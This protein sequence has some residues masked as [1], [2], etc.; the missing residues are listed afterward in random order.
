MPLQRVPLNN[1]RGGLNTRDSPFELQPNESPDLLNVTITD[2]VG[3]LTVRAGKARFDTANMPAH[4][5]DHLQQVV[6]GAST[7]WLMCSINGSVYS[8]DVG[9]ALTLRHAGTAGTVW[10]FVQCIDASGVDQVWMQNGVDTPQKWDGAAASTSDWLATTGSLANS[11]VLRVWRN[12]LTV[13]G[14][15]SDPATSHILYLSPFGDPEATTAAYDFI[16]FRGPDDEEAAITEL[17]VLADRL[18]VFNNRS[19]W[20][21]A[22]PSTLANRRLGQ[23]GCSSRFQSDVCENKLYWFN[24]QGVWST[25]GVAIEYE[26]GSV[27]SYFPANLTMAHIDKVRLVATRDAYPRVMLALPVA[28]SSTNNVLMELVPHINFRR[29]GGR[30]YLL[31]PAFMLHTLACQS[32]GCFKVGGVWGLYAGAGDAN[33]LHRLFAPGTTTDDGVTFDAR[34]QSAWLAIQGEEPFERIRRLNVELSGDAIVDVFKDFAV[35]PDFSATLPDPATSTDNTWDN[36]PHT[37]DEPGQWD[38]PSTYR[39]ARLRP[40]SRGRFHSVRFRSLPG[41]VPFLIN[42]AELAIRGGKEHT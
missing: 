22:D 41:G 38:A 24:E 23:P 6:L 32:L 21:A 20:V 29:I 34:W 13:A 2:L 1:F 5:A 18:Y 27:N 39:F 10:S 17:N 15:P 11:G 14:A 31:L 30:R 42:V 19:V 12:R 26:S 9:G 40:E 36:A 37:W 3:A 8:C 7:R 25:G 28:S 16:E 35:A 4:K 33:K